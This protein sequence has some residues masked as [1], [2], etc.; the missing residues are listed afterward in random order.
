MLIQIKFGEAINRKKKVLYI[1]FFFLIEP[2]LCC[3]RTTSLNQNFL[4]YTG[5]KT[6]HHS[7][8]CY[9]TSVRVVENSKPQPKLSKLYKRKNK[10]TIA[11][12][13]TQPVSEWS[14]TPSR[15]QSFLN[16][17]REKTKTP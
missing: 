13:V 4:N 10:N 17:T 11:P 8:I 6:K 1:I 14:R 15:N 12:F 16:Y 5:E 3:S 2:K 7:S 9:T